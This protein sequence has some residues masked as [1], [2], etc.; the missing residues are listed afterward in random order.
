MFMDAT[1][2]C[3]FK[4]KFLRTGILDQGAFRI[5][6]VVPG[7]PTGTTNE[8]QFVVYG[9]DAA[10]LNKK[11]TPNSEAIIIS[12]ARVLDDQ[13]IEFVVDSLDLIEGTG[14]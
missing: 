7:E 9:T 3:Q 5:M 10:E 11:I 1:N 4:A 6:G 13:K 12:H 14:K 8:I 2:I